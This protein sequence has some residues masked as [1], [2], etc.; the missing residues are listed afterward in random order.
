[1]IATGAVASGP[2]NRLRHSK[3]RLPGPRH[4]VDA[5]GQRP[6]DQVT[7]VGE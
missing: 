2:S 6:L 4:A 7:R 1:M 5:P 3:E